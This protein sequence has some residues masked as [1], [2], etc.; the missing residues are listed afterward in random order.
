MLVFITHP[1]YFDE[2]KI[3][4]KKVE[5][6]YIFNSKRLFNKLS[7]KYKCVN[8]GIDGVIKDENFFPKQVIKESALSKIVD[9]RVRLYGYFKKKLYQIESK[10]YLKRG[11][12]KDSEYK[13]VVK[14][15]YQYKNKKNYID[16]ITFI[17]YN[18]MIII[19]QTAT[20]NKS[21]KFV[22]KYEQFIKV[23]FNYSISF[24]TAYVYSFSLRKRGV[25]IFAD[26]FKYNLFIT[27]T[28]YY[29]FNK[30][31]IYEDRFKYGYLKVLSRLFI[32]QIHSNDVKYLVN[33]Y[34]KEY[35]EEGLL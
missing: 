6:V 28:N 26:I 11:G 20:F 21:S 8:I 5:L 19:N 25:N 34:I 30:Y 18:I 10:F 29:T 35:K 1:K 33:S 3:E 22:E 7:Q 4:N 16:A 13:F 9:F 23:I 14:Y 15:T 12:Y 24:Y 32:E 31:D 27:A 17:D 2:S